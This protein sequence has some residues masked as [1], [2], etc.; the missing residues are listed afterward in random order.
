VVAAFE[1]AAVF[2]GT[3][4]ILAAD[5]A[6][7]DGDDAALADIPAHRVVRGLKCATP[8]QALPG[9]GVPHSQHD[10]VFSLVQV[11]SLPGDA[12]GVMR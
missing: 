6:L 10:G 11:T 5:G 7:L 4:V 8:S 12:G 9:M 3:V 2:Y 1:H